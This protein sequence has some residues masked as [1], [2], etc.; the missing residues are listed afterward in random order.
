MLRVFSHTMRTQQGLLLANFSVL[1]TLKVCPA[2]VYP[3]CN[4][5]L[6]LRAVVGDELN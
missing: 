3:Y 1:A 5:E 6:G 2:I 4:C